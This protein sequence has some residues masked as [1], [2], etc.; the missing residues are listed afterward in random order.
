M[1]VELM[2]Y[3]LN[4]P[5][6]SDLI[7]DNQKRNDGESV[8]MVGDS[9]MGIAI[10]NLILSKRDLKLWC[11]LGAKPTRSWQ[12]SNVKKYFGIKGSKA[13]LMKNFMVLYTDV[14]GDE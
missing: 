4:S 5:F 8:L 11:E 13:T 12:V 9:P 10:W 6:Q 2:T 1:G 3:D 14:M 7:A